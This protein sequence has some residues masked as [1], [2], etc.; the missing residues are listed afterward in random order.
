MMNYKYE[1]KPKE[2]FPPNVFPPQFAKLYEYV[3]Y[4]PDDQEADYGYIERELLNAA[5]SFKLDP[6]LV[7]QLDWMSSR[8]LPPAQPQPQ[9]SQ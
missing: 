5:S 6:S 1:I 2:L 7:I 4:I 8:A 3:R 9:A